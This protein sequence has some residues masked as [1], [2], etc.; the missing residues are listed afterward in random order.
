[1]FAPGMPKWPRRL[2][3]SEVDACPG[4]CNVGWTRVGSSRVESA[5]VKINI[6]SFVSLRPLAFLIFAPLLSALAPPTPIPPSR[7]SNLAPPVA[8]LALCTATPPSRAP[9]TPPSRGPH[10]SGWFSNL[11]NCVVA[12]HGSNLNPAVAGANRR[13]FGVVARV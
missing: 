10:S 7:A 12:A 1:M 11:R 6:A 9:A 5:A 2:K 8:P 4:I 3:F 13:A